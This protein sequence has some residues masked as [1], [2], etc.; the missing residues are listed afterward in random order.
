MKIFP[1]GSVV[2][3]DD[4][5]KIMIFVCLSNAVLIECLAAGKNVVDFFF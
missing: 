1:F 3:H 2:L 4:N 5:C